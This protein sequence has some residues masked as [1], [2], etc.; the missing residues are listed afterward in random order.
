LPACLLACLPAC[1][2]ACLPACLLVCLPAWPY[3]D[4]FLL[5]FVRFGDTSLQESINGDN[6][7]ILSF[8]VQ[9]FKDL[10]PELS[11]NH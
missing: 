8:Y 6:Y 5:L 10:F 7:S 1:L 9:Q 3:N 11:K 4:F 2:L